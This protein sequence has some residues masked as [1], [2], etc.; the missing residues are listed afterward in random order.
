[1]RLIFI[2]T[3]RGYIMLESLRKL[4]S[5]KDTLQTR[6]VV[7]PVCE[8]LSD[9]ETWFN[10]YLLGLHRFG[11][12]VTEVCSME[13]LTFQSTAHIGSAPVLRYQAVFLVKGPMTSY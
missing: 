1:M 10:T 4:V 3:S 7:S 8:N 5:V 6:V 12:I 13:L 2:I 9:L 11:I